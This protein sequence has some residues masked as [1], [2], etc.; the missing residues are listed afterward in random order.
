MEVKGPA[1]VIVG[2]GPGSPDYLTPLARRAVE[3]AEVL[4]GASRLLDLFA[5]HPG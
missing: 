5:E 4:V 3:R 1:I 2:C